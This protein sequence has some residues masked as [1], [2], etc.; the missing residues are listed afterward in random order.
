MVGNV[1]P[2]E[3]YCHHCVGGWRRFLYVRTSLLAV[4]ENPRSAQGHQGLMSVDRKKPSVEGFLLIHYL[5]L[6]FAS[7]LI[8]LLPIHVMTGTAIELPRAL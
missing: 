3:R 8:I 1:C 4:P 5:L 7:S 6:I 2:V